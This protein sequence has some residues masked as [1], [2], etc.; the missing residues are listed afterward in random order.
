[1]RMKH[2]RL[3]TVSLVNHL[4]NSNPELVCER[5]KKRVPDRQALDGAGIL[6]VNSNCVANLGP[7]NRT[8]S[9]L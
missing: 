4:V 5:L 1:M 7:A 3:Y 2:S 6:C 8:E 9:T